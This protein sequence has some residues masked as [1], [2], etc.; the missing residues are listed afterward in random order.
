MEKLGGFCRSGSDARRRCPNQGTT[1]VY[2]VILNN[3][4]TEWFA[5]ECG[6]RQGD[7]LSPTIFGIY[8]NDLI[9]EIKHLDLGIKVNDEKICTLL[10]ADDV[11]IIGNSE[12]ELQSMLNVVSSWGKKYRIR[13][14]AKKTAVVHF[15]QPHIPQT[16][17][18]FYM[19]SQIISSAENYKYLGVFLNEHL[20][21]KVMANN[22]ADAGGR[23]L[24]AIINKYLCIKGLGYYTFTKLYTTCVCPVLDYASEIW[25]LQKSQTYMD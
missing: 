9:T 19:G 15:R 21:Y 4:L 2:F 6:V 3:Q 23:A 17:V 11:V 10:Y 25:G 24:G 5:S 22:L 12:E 14:S 8:I 13:F 20:D 7:I 18:P 16:Q 1:I